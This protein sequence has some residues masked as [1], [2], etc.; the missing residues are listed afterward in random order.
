M[1]NLRRSCF[2][3]KILKFNIGF[4]NG[5]KNWENGFCFRDNCIWIGIV[6]L[7]KLRTGYF[8]SAGNVLPSSPK[9]LHVNKRN[10]FEHNF[11]ASEKWIWQRR[12]DAN[13]NS[14]W[15]HLPYYMSKHPLKW[16]FWYIYLT[17]F[18]ESVTSKIQNLWGSLFDSKISKFSRYFKN[19]GKKWEKVFCVW[20]NCML[21]GIV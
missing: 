21:I 14:V 10:F 12:C 4:K 18:S 11:V 3:S 6:K 9:I 17:T 19:A 20:D 13:F 1:Q 8:S 2:Y 15:A 7:S 5:A 16:D